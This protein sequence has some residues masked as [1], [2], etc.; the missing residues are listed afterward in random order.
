MSKRFVFLFGKV[1][2]PFMSEKQYT[3]YLRK[4]GAVIGKNSA[5]HKSV[6]FGEEAV[7]IHIGN[8]SRITSGC[9]I[10]CHD[11]GIWTLR[12]MGLLED[13]DYFAPVRIGNNVHVGN[14]VVIMPGVCI[15]DNCV[16]GVN[17]VVTHDIPSNS[18]AVG[19]PARVIENIDEY[20]EKKKDKCVRTK[21]MGFDEKS[22]YLLEH[23]K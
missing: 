21:Q 22:K 10:I 19:V 3:N 2:K 12:K 15:G 13:A 23:F 4:L 18:V 16:I 20:Y 1:L 5:V 6:G 14:N 8:N 7:L 11:G 17:A 9:K